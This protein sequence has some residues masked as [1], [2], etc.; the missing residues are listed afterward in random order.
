MSD[1]PQQEVVDDTE[2]S[3][4]NFEQVE[5]IRQK[6]ILS[7]VFDSVKSALFTIMFVVFLLQ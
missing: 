3:E 4:G 1:Q 6:S 2:I 7:R 5:N